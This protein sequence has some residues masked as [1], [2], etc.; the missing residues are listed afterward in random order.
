MEKGT[1]QPFLPQ[2]MRARKE[3]APRPKPRRLIFVAGG[4]TLE[5]ELNAKVKLARVVPCRKRLSPK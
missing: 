4:A 3:K 2:A 5:R 1:T